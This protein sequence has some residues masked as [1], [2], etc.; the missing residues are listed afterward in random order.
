MVHHQ[1]A[2][3]VEKPSLPRK[4]R[5]LSGPLALLSA[6]GKP[7]YLTTSLLHIAWGRL[8]EKHVRPRPL[9]AQT[10]PHSIQPSRPQPSPGSAQT[11]LQPASSSSWQSLCAAA[12][13]T[14]QPSRHHLLKPALLRWFSGA[15][16]IKTHMS[17][18]AY[19]DWLATFLQTMLSTGLP[20]SQTMS[21][22]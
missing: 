2:V 10:Q 13:Q 16:P 17:N 7:P 19:I 3:L 15:Q 21:D 20:R 5:Q 18:A 22:N 12:L 1:Q 8:H 4:P 9:V 6:P 14:A 11:Q